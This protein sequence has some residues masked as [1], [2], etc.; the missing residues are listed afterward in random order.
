MRTR[1]TDLI[2]TM[3]D[4]ER[5]GV[6]THQYMSQ[7]S[8]EENVINNEYFQKALEAG[9][10]KCLLTHQGRDYADN[11]KSGTPYDDLLATHPDLCGVVRDVWL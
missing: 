10:I 8:F 11:D 5:P 1:D 3:V 4:F 9:L 7:S 6:G 2:V